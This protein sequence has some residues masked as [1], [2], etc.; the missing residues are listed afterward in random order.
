MAVITITIED[1]DARAGTVRVLTTEAPPQLG[2]GLTPA[3]AVAMDLLRLCKA[4]AHSVS[5]SHAVP[6][7]VATLEG[8]AQ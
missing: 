6:H 4:H 5:Y 2:R 7:L 8:S 3:Q 1:S